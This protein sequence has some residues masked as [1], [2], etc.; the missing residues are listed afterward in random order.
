MI[1]LF[2][3]KNEQR[4]IPEPS[5]ITLGLERGLLRNSFALSSRFLNR[6]MRGNQ[7]SEEEY[8]KSIYPIVIVF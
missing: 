1:D 3:N 7:P 8:N 5:Q 2:V 4:D 6:K